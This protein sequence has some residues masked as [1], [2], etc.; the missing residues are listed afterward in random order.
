M[1]VIPAGPHPSADFVDGI[2]ASSVR[3][4][5]NMDAEMNIFSDFKTES[6]LEGFN[7]IQQ[8]LSAFET[9]CCLDSQL[10]PYIHDFAHPAD[11]IEKDTAM[12]NIMQGHNANHFGVVNLPAQT[13]GYGRG[14]PPIYLGETPS[15]EN[16]AWP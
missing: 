2:A 6:L 8:L 12:A 14:F 10:F 3:P 13:C 11:I 5:V 4:G 9:V 7:G 16:T 1:D 15:P